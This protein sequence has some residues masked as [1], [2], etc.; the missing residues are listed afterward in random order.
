MSGFQKY[1]YKSLQ[2][3]PPE[4][5]QGTAI[6]FHPEKMDE[7]SAK[8]VDNLSSRRN[9]GFC[10][11]EKVMEQLGL[12]KREQQRIE[13][14]LRIEFE[15]RWEQMKE[16]AEAEGFSKGLEDG[17]QEAFHAELPRIQEK[18]ESLNR[19]TQELDKLREKIFVA[20]E[21]FLMDLIGQVARV[22][23]L[24]EVELDQEYIHRLVV[25][26]L[27]Q[28]GTKEDL[29]IYVSERDAVNIQALKE[30]LGK[31]FGKLTN[32]TIEVAKDLSGGGC[33]NETR[34]GVVNAS[35]QT[36]IDNIAHSLRA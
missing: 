23:T 21:A 1:E 30:I 34:F 26:L 7:P 19:L 33:R 6:D 8:S 35:V 29:K 22:V 11:D 25:A 3:K 5:T 9:Q 31:E 2:N 15:K 16:R 14:N 10:L 32:T 4:K 18:L 13:N 17:K 12:E 36:Q 24:R 20:N 28:L 27:Q